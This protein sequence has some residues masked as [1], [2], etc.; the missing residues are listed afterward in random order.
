MSSY[1]PV[2]PKGKLRKLKNYLNFFRRPPTKGEFACYVIIVAIVV[3][4]SLFYASHTEKRAAE[5]EAR[6]LAKIERELALEAERN[7]PFSPEEIQIPESE[8]SFYEQLANRTFHIDGEEV[9]GGAEYLEAKT[10]PPN[11]KKQAN[12]QNGSKFELISAPSGYESVDKELKNE[13]ALELLSTSDFKEP[14]E[15]PE[16]GPKKNLQTG[17]FSS[18]F[19]AN[20]HKSQLESMGYKPIVQKAVVNGKTTYRVQIGPFAPKDLAQTKRNLD[21]Q[22][23][24]FIEVKP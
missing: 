10:L 3:T 9:I 7:K 11:E 2:E 6:M 12:I 4:G 17:S 23:V 1:S 21:E 16:Q 19:E 22:H 20:I 24:K 15:K 13:L 14:I 18:T 8:F 5:K